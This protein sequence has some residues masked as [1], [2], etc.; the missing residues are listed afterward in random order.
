MTGQEAGS[1]RLSEEELRAA[2]SSAGRVAARVTHHG[3]SSRR[4]PRRCRAALPG[5][6][7]RLSRLDST[8]HRR[9][10]L[11][12]CG[13][14]AGRRELGGGRRPAML[15]L[16]LPTLSAHARSSSGKKKRRLSAPARCAPVAVPGLPTSR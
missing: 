15:L 12:R 10:S 14:A 1:A 13:V 2:R 4:S 9:P 16:S 5:S 11:R 8:A 3:H 6:P 7:V